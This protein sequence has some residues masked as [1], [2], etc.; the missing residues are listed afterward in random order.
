MADE[1][2][3]E[4]FYKVLGDIESP[5]GLFMHTDIESFDFKPGLKYSRTDFIS[6]IIRIISPYDTNVQTDMTGFFGF[7]IEKNAEGKNTI[8]GYPSVVNL[9][10]DD[11]A[12]DAVKIFDCVKRFTLDNEVV[13]YNN[14]AMTKYLNVIVKA[15]PEFLTLID[16]VQHKTHSY[17]VDVHTL[18]VLQGVMQ[19]LK[20]TFLPEEDRRVL[21]I[22]VLLHDITKKE[23][24]I[25][26]SH[27]TCGAKDTGFILNK[28][29][30]TSDLRKRICL[31]IKNHDWLERYNKG[32]TSAEDFADELK[33]GNDFLMLAI[34]AE[35]DLKAV[36]RDGEFYE[37]YKDVLDRGFKEIS[38]LIHNHLS[39]A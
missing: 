34:M 21:Q 2:L 4:Q 39:A 32:L 7:L 12:P 14:K 1:K 30:M 15:L 19:N 11:I 5:E 10:R 35:A 27:P 13:V 26:K 31:I 6:D 3:K 36:K 37:R 24:E 18:K 16:K 23:G 38:S 8:K 17:S 33:N 25:D 22:A 20:Y 29:G 9:D 28:F